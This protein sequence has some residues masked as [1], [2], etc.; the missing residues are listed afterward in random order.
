MFSSSLGQVAYISLAQVTPRHLRPV[1]SIA[2]D[3]PVIL[4][5]FSLVRSSAVDAAHET[6]SHLHL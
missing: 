3:S 2:L 6:N 4:P 5:L 1:V